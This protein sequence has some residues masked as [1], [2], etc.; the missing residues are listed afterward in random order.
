MTKNLIVILGD[1]LNLNISSLKDFDLREDRILLCEVW[2]EATYV[3]HHKKKIVFI[4]SAMRHFRVLLEKSGFPVT[5]VKLDD[6]GNTGTFLS[7]VKRA[8]NKYSPDKV[9]V[10]EPGEYRV[11]RDI[12][13]WKKNLNIPV[14][15]LSDDRFL[16]SHD[17]FSNWANGRKE[18]RMEYF[19]REIR[20][21]YKI[22]MDG[23][24]PEGGKWNYDS[25]NRKPLK[26][27][28]IIPKTF[29][30]KTDTIT[31]EVIS[32][33]S[34]SFSDHFGDIKPFHYAVTRD[35]A[36][37]ALK[38]FIK[39]RLTNFG[40]YQDAMV[41]GEPWLFHSHIGL[42]LNSGLLLPLECVKYAEQAYR[43]GFAPLNAVEGFIRQ[44]IG[45]REFVRG[46]YWLKMPKY[47]PL[48][49]LEA[50]R[51]LPNFFWDG[52]TKMNCLSQCIRDTKNNAYA[53]HIQRLMVLGNFS[54][55]SGLNPDEV[56][57]WYMIVYIDAFEWVELPNVSGMILFADGGLLASKPY[58]ASGSY[59]NKM[60][61]YCKKCSYN[62]S[63]K[64]GEDA[65]PFNYL[66]WNF[67]IQNIEKLRGN[68]RL[69]LIYKSLERMDKN[70][71]SLIK[72]D[73]DRFFASLDT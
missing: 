17:E 13:N 45:W 35:Q 19:Y 8:E 44:I 57:E 41:Q 26:E 10:T 2:E 47:K 37:K 72:A 42:Y 12:Q 40:D 29:M 70:K 4:F 64:N 24:K 56:N 36:L 69:S 16:T 30:L 27:K 60:S 43:R 46:I 6:P 63:Q 39:E 62:V 59:I 50:K 11:L 28:I 15:I 22:L 67:L 53:H 3:K 58:A 1:Q 25:E 48:N 51:K 38:K 23:I 14:E 52:E 65:C 7:E 5:Y 20:K 49:F 71:V 9:I 55:I 18:L 54:L 21:N 68:Q 73:S 61:D 34:K 66:Y 32:L 33:V 31:N